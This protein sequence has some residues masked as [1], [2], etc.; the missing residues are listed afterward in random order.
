VV[1][2]VQT[3]FLRDVSHGG[4]GRQPAQVARALAR[5]VSAASSSLQ[6]AIYDFRLTDHLAGPVVR[7]FTN[8][9]AR[10][11]QVQIA[12]DRQDKPA[13]QTT[14]AF[15]A[16][17]GDPAPS[18]THEWLHQRLDG[19]GVGLQPVHSPS[20]Q[21]MH[22]KYMIRDGNTP[23]AVVWTGSANF[24]DAAWTRQENN[25]VQVASTALAG[26]Y[27]ADFDQLWQ[28]GQIT[29]TGAGDTGTTTLGATTVGWAFAPGGGPTIDAHLAGLISTARRRIVVASMVLTS[30]TILGALTD[31]LDRGIPLSG[32]Y[33]AGQMAPILRQWRK[34][35]TGKPT[36][37]LFDRIAGHL[38]GKKSAPYTPDGPH[39]F[40]HHKVLVCDDTVATGSFNLSHNA[41]GN[42]ENSITLHSPTLARRYTTAITELT[43]TYTTP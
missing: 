42:A 32:I 18:G 37:A 43:H 7:A 22:H 41:A 27:Q 16:V 5:F 21:L 3:R 6:V 29:G 31:A 4:A 38:T 26:A 36:A 17:G 1:D 2:V 30:H 13:A 23:A 34:T 20:G 28:T 9:A 10:G 14:A 33:D 11:V 39:D 12:Y 19:S 15:A 35:P 40:M 8:A 24:T 25:I